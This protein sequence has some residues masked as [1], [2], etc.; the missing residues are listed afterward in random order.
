MTAK[1]LLLASLLVLATPATAQV[2]YDGV[3]LARTNRWDSYPTHIFD[4]SKHTIWWCSRATVSGSLDTYVDSIFRSQKTGSLGPGGWSSFLEVLKNTQTPWASNHVC[5]PSVLRGTFSYNNHAY[6]HILFWTSDTNPTIGGVDNAVGVAFSDDGIAWTVHPTAVIQSYNA[7]NGTY[8][9]GAGGAAIDPLTSQITYAYDD[10]TLNPQSRLMTSSNALNWA[11][12]P[13]T[14]TMIVSSGRTLANSS[15]IAYYPADQHWYAAVQTFDTQGIYSGETRVLRSTNPNQLTGSWT[16]VASLS[17][18]LTGNQINNNPG[19]G[20]LSNGNL[21]VDAQ[22]WAYV[23]F[24]TGPADDPWKWDVAQ[25]RFRPA[26]SPSQIAVSVDK[27]RPGYLVASAGADP[28]SAT[29]APAAAVVS[30]PGGTTANTDNSWNAMRDFNGKPGFNAFVDSPTEASPR[31]TLS[32][33][34]LLNGVSYDVYCRFGTANLQSPPNFYGIEMGITAPLTRYD[35]TS[36]SYTLVNNWTNWQE[37]EVYLGIETVTNG[38]LTVLV[39]DDSVTGTAA[40]TG[41]RLVRR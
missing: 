36:S 9:A 33:Q 24:G 39:D 15:D 1:G 18:S 40:W 7:Y 17:S 5:D 30:I 26:S 8:G 12:S 21:F 3:I 2:Q 11:P 34:W 37:R 23:F 29:Y 32:V 6:S 13:P 25:A 20:R 16:T 4:G 38:V 27:D 22:G 31:L 10:S 28:V 41:L 35:Q 14:T 19:L